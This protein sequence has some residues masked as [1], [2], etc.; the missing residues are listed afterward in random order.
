MS[1]VGL[2]MG[3]SDVWKRKKRKLESFSTSGNLSNLFQANS[4]ETG[5]CDPPIGLGITCFS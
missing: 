1:R 2:V 3:V 4:T 5:K